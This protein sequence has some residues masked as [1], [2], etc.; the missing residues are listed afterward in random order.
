MKK[1]TFIALLFLIGTVI[2]GCTAKR[3]IKRGDASML[4]N[5]PADAERYYRE[6]LEH[7]SDLAEKPA[8]VEKFKRARSLAAYEKGTSLANQGLWEQA[9]IKFS[10]TLEIDPES[11]H[12]KRAIIQAQARRDETER[13][14]SDA[15]HLAKQR[16]W[17]DAIRQA[18]AALK[19]SPFHR[20]ASDVLAVA[21][22]SAAAEHCEAGNRLLAGN[23]LAEAEMEFRRSLRYIPTLV[24]AREGLARAD[25]IRGMADQEKGLWGSALLWY[26]DANN[27]ISKREYI[28]KIE[29]ARNRVFSRIS[30]GIGVNVTDAR[31]RRT[32]ES[33]AL[34]SRVFANIS[35][36]KPPFLRIESA[37]N[38]A[39]PPSY[40]VSVSLEDLSVRGGQGLVRSENRTHYY[41]A[42]R[43]IPNPE[44]PR[45]RIL[46]RIARRDLARLRRD[47][48]RKGHA[49]GKFKRSTRRGK[50]RAPTRR[51]QDHRHG[52]ATRI[53]KRHI[54]RKRAQVRHLRHRLAVAPYTITESFS[55]NWPYVINYYEK[56]GVIRASIRITNAD[57][58][59]ID[60][61]TV[62]KTFRQTD[63]TIDNPN[64]RIGLRVDPL[65][66]CSN[67]EARTS[68]IRA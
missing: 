64:P 6:A 12:A 40:T 46:L 24:P 23:N 53:T 29:A 59:T 34:R 42:Y 66:L 38:I 35:A 26:T 55:A 33:S 63:T 31:V 20:P 36:R 3:L 17:D 28:D 62:R 48:N 4:A 41:T 44:I 65:I 58:V 68:L 11:A 57:G 18:E 32:V 15:A 52:K 16:R 30:F 5:R 8:F 9:I 39:N 37:K 47:F 1:I 13:L 51:P 60:A 2:S 19:I 7:D 49:T 43:K 25:C 50:R 27:H 45:L 21:K 56:S 67:D 54:E 61:I 14:Y 10:E 22:N